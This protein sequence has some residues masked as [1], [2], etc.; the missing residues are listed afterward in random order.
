M[1]KPIR[2]SRCDTK[3]STVWTSTMTS[4]CGSQSKT[5]FSNKER[6]HYEGFREN[7]DP[8][9]LHAPTRKPIA[10]FGA[11]NSR[12]GLLASHQEPTYRAVTFRRFLGVLHPRL[13]QSPPKNPFPTMR[14]LI[15]SAFVRS[16]SCPT[17]TRPPPISLVSNPNQAALEASAGDSDLDRVLSRT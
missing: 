9:L 8:M 7:I 3:R 1:L 5:P 14:A 15:V 2:R 12:H 4:N 6:D 16:I 13:P 17:T 11:T 10:L